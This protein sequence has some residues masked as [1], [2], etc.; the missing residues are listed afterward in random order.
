MA[1]NGSGSPKRRLSRTWWRRVGFALCV[2]AI[3]WAMTGY[4]SRETVSGVAPEFQGMT[5]DG[6]PFRLEDFRGQATLV[7]FWASWC[8]ACRLMEE[9]V[10]EVAADE[11]RQVNT[12][13]VRSGPAATVQ[14]YLE[15]A[16]VQL[17]V[18]PDPH[19][20]LAQR[21]GVTALP[22]S[23]YL[24]EAG[25]VVTTEVGMTSSWGMRMRMWW[26]GP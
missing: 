6:E 1:E 9:S 20:A 12:I 15:E 3:Y 19:G 18:I 21:F 17:P 24:N 16:A 22:T 13:A 25:E 4:Q 8:G 10:A 14:A 26:V 23:F 2:F 5:I 11:G 7:H